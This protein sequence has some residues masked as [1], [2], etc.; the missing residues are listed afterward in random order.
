MTYGELPAS[1]R[2]RRQ[3]PARGKRPGYTVE[4]QPVVLFCPRCLGEFS[5]TRGD[6]FM[7]DPREVIKH[8]GR[9]MQLIRWDAATYHAVTPAEM[10]EL[11]EWPEGT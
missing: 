2:T 1:D 10:V 7:R 5:A 4:G 3:V 8:C 6:Y 9:P 11:R